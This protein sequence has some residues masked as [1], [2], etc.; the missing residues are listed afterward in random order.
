M[1]ETLEAAPDTT[2]TLVTG[3]KFVVKT[4]VAEVIEQIIAYRRKIGEP[5]FVE[6]DGA[7]KIGPPFPM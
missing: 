5:G 7:E 6:R 4:P 3:R 2:I 1:I